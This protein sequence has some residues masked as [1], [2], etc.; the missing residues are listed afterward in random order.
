MALLAVVLLLAFGVPV[1]PR[2]V[3]LLLGVPPLIAL[4]AGRAKSPRS[5][6]EVTG[7]EHGGFQT[8]EAL[9]RMIVDSAPDGMLMLDD[10]GR[11]LEAN[12]AI[13]R[14][15]G[16]E[17]DALLRMHV[18][19]WQA[20]FS[21]EQV[22][23]MIR[24]GLLPRG[25]HRFETTHRR[26]DGSTYMAEVSVQVVSVED[27]RV[28]IASVRDISERTAKV[29]ERERVHAQLAAHAAMQADDLR[30]AQALAAQAGLAK[31]GFLANVAQHLRTPTHSVLAFAGLGLQHTTGS[32]TP[33]ETCFERILQSAEQLDAFVNDLILLTGLQ[34]GARRVSRAPV[35]LQAQ[36]SAAH[37]EMAVSLRRKAL[38]LA[39]D[40][41]AGVSAMLDTALLRRLLVALLAHACRRSPEDG[42]I[43]LTVREKR[44]SA[45]GSA[46]R[47]GFSL[48][49]RDRG[50]AVDDALSTPYFD[51]F[52][53]R[54]APPAGGDTGLALAL[55]AQIVRA[56][57]GTI[58][59]RGGE[60]D[61]LTVVVWLPSDGPSP[62]A[63][64]HDPGAFV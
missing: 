14:T 3:A 12:A 60:H 11:V 48:S 55:A 16:V 44:A 35:N 38:H 21:R 33:A 59:A 37:S 6:R 43:D 46:V 52:F 57:G 10:E 50:P 54:K 53:A 1:G 62:A 22:R 19:D 64:A 7:V 31:D 18:G 32:D 45:D 42:T 9:C 28:A 15:L 41:P 34:S 13:C 58:S 30:A 47:R 2:D 40:V 29:R 61:G 25:P 49:V 63:A 8:G 4:L 36:V 24:D 39:S 17:R 26:A 23:A 56:H 27:R 20:E 5:L 51:A